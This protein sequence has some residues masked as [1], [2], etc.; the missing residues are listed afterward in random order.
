MVSWA[1][2]LTFSLLTVNVTHGWIGLCLGDT[3]G[4]KWVD[5][6]PTM[7]IVVIKLCLLKNKVFGF[8]NMHLLQNYIVF[9]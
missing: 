3:Q 6:R 4:S 8:L 2:W 5:I 1:D 7:E 9:S